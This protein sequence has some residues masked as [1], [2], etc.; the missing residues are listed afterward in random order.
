MAAMAPAAAAA[1]G[2]QEPNLVLE[3]GRSISAIAE[4]TDGELV[5]TDLGS[6]ELLHIVAVPD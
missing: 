4:T 6:G 5:A 1:D 3:S 2:F